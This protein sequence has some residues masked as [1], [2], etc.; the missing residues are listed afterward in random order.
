MNNHISHREIGSPLTDLAI[1]LIESKEYET[2]SYVANYLGK[3]KEGRHLVAST[4]FIKENNKL[5]GLY[6]LTTILMK[7]RIYLTILKNSS[8]IMHSTQILT[9]L[10][11]Q[12]NFDT[13]INGHM[14]DIVE[15]EIN[16]SIISPDRMKASERK[17]IVNKLNDYGVFCRTRNDSFVAENYARRNQ[18]FT[19]IS[20]KS[21]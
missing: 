9:K 14:Y 2:K 5:I 1:N 3:T 7:Y 11:Y 10:K 19:D 20:K 21:K 15:R 17:V 6:A 13:N 8:K 12:E 18:L 4:F 16:D